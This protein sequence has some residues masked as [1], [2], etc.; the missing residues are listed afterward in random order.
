MLEI[1]TK[2]KKHA[3]PG[4]W[5]LKLWLPLKIRQKSNARCWKP[6]LLLRL[7][8]LRINAYFARI[9]Q[10]PCKKKQT[11]YKNLQGIF[12][13]QD[14]TWKCFPWKILQG[15]FFLQR[16]CKE[17]FSLK[18]LARVFFPWKILQRNTSLARFLSS[19]Y[20][21]LKNYVNV[22]VIWVS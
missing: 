4:F 12:F 19:M 11:T 9:L 22:V 6:R 15:N 16:S 8:W 2:S 1:E 3:T 13:L 5:E 7:P 17:M 21:R 20:F 18:D 10:D 14:L